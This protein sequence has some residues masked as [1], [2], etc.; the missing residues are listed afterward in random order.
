MKKETI[1]EQIVKDC[2]EITRLRRVVNPSSTDIEIIT[3][4]YRKYID[5]SALPPILSCNSCDRSIGAYY[6]K[7]V[8]LPSGY[9]ELK[10]IVK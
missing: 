6:W 3:L 4:L 7:V 2:E 8:A 10:N 1:D 9:N 5:R